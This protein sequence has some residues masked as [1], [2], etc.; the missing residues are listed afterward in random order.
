MNSLE[1][2]EK[3]ILGMKVVCRGF[4][5]SLALAGLEGQDPCEHS[6]VWFFLFQMIAFLTMA[7]LNWSSRPHLRRFK[8]GNWQDSGQPDSNS[9]WSQSEDPELV[10]TLPIL[11]HT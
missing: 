5:S 3:E 4:G 8:V 1:K 7:R 2:P 11:A 6:V 10:L 9:G